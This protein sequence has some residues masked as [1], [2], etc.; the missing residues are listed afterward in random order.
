MEE[1][2]PDLFPLNKPEATDQWPPQPGSGEFCQE[3]KAGSVLGLTLPQAPHV[4]TG[5]RCGHRLVRSGSSSI[6]V[7]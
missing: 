3:E 6:F 7:L 5:P 1:W 4:N 2:G